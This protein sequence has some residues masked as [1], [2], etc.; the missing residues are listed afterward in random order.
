ME[1][2]FEKLEWRLSAE[3]GQKLSN[4]NLKALLAIQ[5]QHE[6]KMSPAEVCEE[7]ISKQGV[8]SFGPS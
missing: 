7:M 8:N 3:E 4:V 5:V 6:E 2:A 1:N